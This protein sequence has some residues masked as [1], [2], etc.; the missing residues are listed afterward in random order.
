MHVFAKVNG[1][2]RTIMFQDKEIAQFTRRKKN[3]ERSIEEH[4]WVTSIDCKLQKQLYHNE[5]MPHPEYDLGLSHDEL[6]QLM[7]LPVRLNHAFG[8]ISNQ[9]ELQAHFLLHKYY[10]IKSDHDDWFE[11]NESIFFSENEWQK[12]DCKLLGKQ[13]A[14][15]DDLCSLLEYSSLK[16]VLSEPLHDL[17]AATKDFHQHE[18]MKKSNKS[19]TEIQIIHHLDELKELQED[20]AHQR[21]KRIYILDD[22]G[23]VNLKELEFNEIEN[24]RGQCHLIQLTC[25]EPTKKLASITV[26]IIFTGK[27]TGSDYIPGRLSAS[28]SRIQNKQSNCNKIVGDIQYSLQTL[29]TLKSAGHLVIEYCVENHEHYEEPAMND[30]LLNISIFACSSCT[31]S[32]SLF[33]RF[34]YDLE[35][36]YINR[37]HSYLIAD[38]KIQDTQRLLHDNYL[39]T[40]FLEYK[41]TML[42][43]I[44]KKTETLKLE[45]YHDIEAQELNVSDCES[46]DNVK[47]RSITKVCVLS[48]AFIK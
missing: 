7:M 25:D 10:T 28:I 12:I 40:R 29:N 47:P 15:F 45:L 11:D 38:Q 44:C 3:I 36:Y 21:T 13:L 2:L 20:L 41:Y 48:N 5:Y 17:N 9:K 43:L 22:C 35:S 37:L 30:I 1:S 19:N 33:G 39:N 34:M 8:N 27:H 46:S 32:I 16:N 14:S 31:Y 4:Q 24:G 6:L 42:S 23:Y 18:A 26:S